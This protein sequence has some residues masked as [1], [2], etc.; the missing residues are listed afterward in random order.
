MPD[1]STAVSCLLQPPRTPGGTRRLL[2][3]NLGDSR[4]ALVRADGSAV[5]LSVDHKPNRP[6][7]RERVMAAGGH[8]IFA[9]CWRVPAWGYAYGFGQGLG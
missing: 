3:A 8:V 2:V 6:D 9:G 1:G 5:A 7:E 4:C